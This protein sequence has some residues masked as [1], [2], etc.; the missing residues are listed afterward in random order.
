MGK[1][2]LGCN[3][4]NH[5]S[6]NSVKIAELDKRLI[7]QKEAADHAITLAANDLRARLDAMNEFRA[8]LK[9]QSASFVSR[10]ELERRFINLEEDVISLKLSKAKL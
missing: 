6:I 8:A 4:N 7:I 5:E 3:D 2:T 9:D 1:E 10:T